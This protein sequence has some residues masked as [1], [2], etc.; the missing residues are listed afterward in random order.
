[1]KGLLLISLLHLTAISSLFAQITITS[2]DFAS[3]GDTVRM[4]L[5]TDPSID[6][7][8]T[9]ANQNWDYSYLSVE[10]QKLVEYFDIAGFPDPLVLLAYGPFAPVKYQATYTLPSV[11]LPLDQIGPIVGISI[12]DPLAYHRLSNDSLSMVG[13]SMDIEGTVIPFKSDS[14]EAYYKFPLNYQDTYEGSGVTNIDLNPFYSGAW[15]QKRYRSSEVDG[16]G[17]ITT[18]YGTFNALRIRHTIDEIDSIQVDLFGNLTWISLPIPVNYVYEW[19]TNGEKDAILRVNTRSI[20]G[21]EVVTGIE[22]RDMYRS[23]A[24]VDVIEESS[25][26]NVY[27]SPARDMLKIE[28]V[29]FQTPYTIYD[30][31]GRLVMSGILNG[32]PIDLGALEKGS[33]VLVVKANNGVIQSKTFI[34]N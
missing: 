24:L 27:P 31:S 17:S 26:L 4:S 6:I 5:A 10:N 14:I 18:P 20:A 21:N 9:G 8:S 30:H 19:W 1:M 29:A 23:I 13:Y 3:N 34:K 22:F 11:N 33:Y 12:S 7:I 28:G 2:S 16:W 32:T 25:N 15:I